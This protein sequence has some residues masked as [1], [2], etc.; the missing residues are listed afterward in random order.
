[1]ESPTMRLAQYIVDN[2]FADFPDIVI[3]KAKRCIMDSLGCAFGGYQSDA[4]KHVAGL[5]A[6]L[7]GRR[8]ATIIGTGE[9]GAYPNAAL[10]NTY[11]ANILDFDDTFMGHPGCTTV[12]PAV[13]GGEMVGASGKDLLTSVIVGYEVYTHIA[14]AMHYAPGMADK[15]SGVAV[16]TFSAVASASK[17][18]A[19][20]K[21]MILDALGIAGATAPVQSNA[22]TGGSEEMPPTMKVGFYQCSLVGT[23]SALLAKNGVTGPHSI[24]DGDTGFWRM[25]GAESCDFDKIVG[26]LG[27]EYNTMNIAFKPYSCCRWFHSSLDAALAI[28][29]EEKFDLSSIQNID[30]KTFGGKSDKTLAYMKNPHPGNIVAAEFSLPYSMAV[31]LNGIKPGPEWFTTTTMKDRKVLELASKIK[32]K[33]ELKSETDRNDYHKMPANV[34]I[35]TNQGT[36]SK[37]I[38]YPKGSPQNMLTINELDAKFMRLTQEVLGEDRAKD[39][40]A[41]VNRLEK[42]SD[43]AEL[44]SLLIPSKKYIR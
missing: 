30:V 21:D 43:L 24:L 44:S 36:Y 38:E 16:Q 40:K 35:S 28:I 1:M 8:D 31:A 18:L 33:F 23:T 17:V 5:M 12:H 13:G 29:N 3:E 34:E 15:L 39:L 20:N 4:G 27:K 11:L 25:I 19:L 6:G 14:Q 22:K 32:C 9:K 42:L 26:G 41:L 37:R 7:G 2:D 10:A